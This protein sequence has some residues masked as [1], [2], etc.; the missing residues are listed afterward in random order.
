M[1][2][3]FTLTEILIAIAII[4]L[5]AAITFPVLSKARESGYRAQS[6]T[7]LRQVGIGIETYRSDYD[8]MLAFRQLDPYVETRHINDTRL[9]YSQPDEFKSGYGYE[10]SQ[11]ID[12]TSITSLRTSY[13][14]S[15]FA[16]SFYDRLKFIDPDAA[17]VVDRTHGATLAW[18]RTGT[19]E[20]I[21]Y[22]YSGRI[23]RLYEDTH[24]KIG[25]FSLED[26]VSSPEIGIA[27]HRLKMF[28]DKEEPPVSKT[29]V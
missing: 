25:Q 21:E 2:R 26:R 3:G 10:V 24:V 20:R 6:I 27:W 16:K 17:I 14:T 28:T 1:R 8:G 5:L 4:L 15:L 22:F 13:E 19:C 7:H 11:C 23:L 29:Q 18:A 12:R 9:L